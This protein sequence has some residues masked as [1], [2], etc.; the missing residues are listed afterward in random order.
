[1]YNLNSTLNLILIY[2]KIAFIFIFIYIYI[3]IINDKDYS[4]D[5]LNKKN[6]YVTILLLIIFFL[7]IKPLLL[8]ML[9]TTTLIFL[10]FIIK[11]IFKKEIKMLKYKKIS[12]FYDFFINIYIYKYNTVFTKIYIAINFNKLKNIGI[13]NKINNIKSIILNLFT[14]YILGIPMTYVIL[15]LNIALII[16][17]S[18]DNYNT[19]L[20]KEKTFF[21][22]FFLI[23]LN[24]IDHFNEKIYCAN[25]IN[26]KNII[27]KNLNKKNGL[28]EFYIKEA[29]EVI[30]NQPK[31][32]FN[33]LEIKKKFD[34]F[35]E[36]DENLNKIYTPSSPSSYSNIN[37]NKK[38]LDT[39][40]QVIEVLAGNKKRPNIVH[41][42]VQIEQQADE[43]KNYIIAEVYS[44]ENKKKEKILN[45]SEVIEGKYFNTSAEINIINTSLTKTNKNLNENFKENNYLTDN[46]KEHFFLKNR[47]EKIKKKILI[48]DL[49]IK[50]IEKNEEYTDF[51]SNHFEKLQSNV[52]E[53]I[54]EFNNDV[55]NIVSI[56]SKD[57]NF[58]DKNPHVQKKIIQNINK[59]IEQLSN[60]EFK[61]IMYNLYTEK[62]IEQITIKYLNSLNNHYS[63]KNNETKNNVDDID[64][65]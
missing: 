32:I 18:I 42:G 36:N 51:L 46:K 13:K 34:Y 35:I 31:K 19:H 43:N 45:N 7:L 17:K 39:Q 47:V 23:Y 64:D 24:L 55:R 37:E 40:F 5:S 50:V 2:Y 11:S 48:E 65:F 53:I 12:K 21:I 63:I 6:V 8:L 10:T 28:M 60:E 38:T 15:I 49:E 58:L 4:F 56:M 57:S 33:F 61:S 25:I 52:S 59:Q 9:L 16:S 54:T 14:L 3:N 30:S 1:M 26:N 41:F 62:E 44:T 22:I 29:M 27:F 20:K